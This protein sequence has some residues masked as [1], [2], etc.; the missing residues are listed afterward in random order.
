MCPGG[1]IVGDAVATGV[2]GDE[3]LLLTSVEFALGGVD[4]VGMGRSGTSVGVFVYL[5]T[6]DVFPAFL[7]FIRLANYTYTFE[8][9]RIFSIS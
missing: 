8:S 6:A 4:G 2:G 5:F 1:A 9:R 3:G 7:Y